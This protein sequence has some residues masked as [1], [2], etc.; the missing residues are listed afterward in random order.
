MLALDHRLDVVAEDHLGTGNEFRLHYID[1]LVSIDGV[2]S[3]LGQLFGNASAQNGGA[4]QTYDGI[5]GS[6]VDEMGNQLISGSLGFAEAGLLKG[7][8][9]IIIDVAVVGG[10]VTTGHPQGYIA[11]TAFQMLEFNHSNYLLCEAH[12]NKKKGV[13]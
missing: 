11:A 5:Y 8:I 10:E 13:L 9:N 4:I 7:D 6:I 2:E 12:S 1:G 3:A